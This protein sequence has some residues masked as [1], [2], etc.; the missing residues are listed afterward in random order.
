LL[1]SSVPT[2]ENGEL[3]DLLLFDSQLVEKP[4]VR[5]TFFF[6]RSSS[7]T[8][9]RCL[10]GDGSHH[11]KAWPPR[12]RPRNQQCLLR[13]WRSR[14]LLSFRMGCKVVYSI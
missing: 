7:N 1:A 14:S 6:P 11:P 13:K 3:V 4:S 2:L 10:T 9:V 8:C 5:S 12:S